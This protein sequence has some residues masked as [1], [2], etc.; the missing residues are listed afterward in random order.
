MLLTVRGGHV[1]LANLIVVQCSSIMAGSLTACLIF[2]SL[3]VQVALRTFMLCHMHVFQLACWSCITFWI[4]HI[5]L[6]WRCFQLVKVFHPLFPLYV[7]P[8][9]HCPQEYVWSDCQLYILQPFLYIV[10]VAQSEDAKVS[11][12]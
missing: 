3:Y 8:S 11:W 10:M 7:L 12:H 1:V 5:H 2:S 6:S 4:F 9:M